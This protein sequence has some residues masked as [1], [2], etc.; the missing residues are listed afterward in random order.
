MFKS[1][2]SFLLRRAEGITGMEFYGFRAIRCLYKGFFSAIDFL[3]DLI[4]YLSF[5]LSVNGITLP[6]IIASEAIDIV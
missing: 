3:Y 5:Q 6:L 4:I 1:I 2:Y